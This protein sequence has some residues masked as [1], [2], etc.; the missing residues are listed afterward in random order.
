MLEPRRGGQRQLFKARTAIELAEE[1]KV[2]LAISGVHGSGCID[3]RR[4]VDAGRE[5]VREMLAPD[6]RAEGE[7]R[8]TGRQ[9]DQIAVGL[10]GQFA[11]VIGRVRTIEQSAR[12]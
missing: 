10:G 11:K 2:E 3:T 4:C 7:L 12:L 8:G 9:G 1:G 6:R 5:Q